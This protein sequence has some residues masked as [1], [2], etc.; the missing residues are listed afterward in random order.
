MTYGI[1]KVA[2]T[3]GIGGKV[4]PAGTRVVI[5]CWAKVVDDGHCLVKVGEYG[6]PFDTLQKYVEVEK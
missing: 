4:V 3:R 1:L 2:V 6:R 5:V